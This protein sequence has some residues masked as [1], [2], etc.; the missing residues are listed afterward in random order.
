M[1]APRVMAGF[2]P[3]THDFC[4]SPSDVVGHDV[5]GKT[6]LCDVHP[7]ALGCYPSLAA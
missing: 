3:A 2:S 5:K 4:A 7:I 1:A 6:F